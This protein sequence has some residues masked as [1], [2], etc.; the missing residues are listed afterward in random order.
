MARE[1]GG[2]ERDIWWDRA[3]AVF[4]PFENYAQKARRPIPIFALEPVKQTH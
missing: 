3:V 4:P 2:S 1:L